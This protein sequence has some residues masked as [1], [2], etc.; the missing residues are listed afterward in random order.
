MFC[1]A[2]LCDAVNNA[3]NFRNPI[4]SCSTETQDYI[5]CIIKPLGEFP[6][7]PL[8]LALRI[9]QSKGSFFSFYLILKV[10]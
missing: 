5:L 7:H 8:L 4:I 9:S 6:Q 1:F 2:S 3:D 10:E